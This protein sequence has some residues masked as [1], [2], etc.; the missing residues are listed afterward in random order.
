MCKNV[1]FW[2]SGFILCAAISLTVVIGAGAGD[3]PDTPSE[4]K[5]LKTLLVERRTVL[6]EAVRSAEQA[7]RAGQ[8]RFDAVIEL[9][10][11]LSHA[12]LELATTAEERI[13]VR[14]R[15]VNE[16]TALEQATEEQYKAGQATRVDCLKSTAARLQA[17][18]DLARARSQAAETQQK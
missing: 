8:S 12:D 5:E 9:R 11:E 2:V 17:Q 13:A 7:F 4:D 14:R 16:I 6:Q 3:A 10:R 15:L 1:S 18:I